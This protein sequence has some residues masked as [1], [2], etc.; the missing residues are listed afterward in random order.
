MSISLKHTDQFASD[1]VGVSSVG[2]RIKATRESLGY[3]VDDLAVTCGL[4][5]DEIID[6]EEGRDAD[7]ARLKRIAPALQVSVESLLAGN[8]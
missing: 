5:N 4:A 7:P 1:A 8:A 3:S 6:I 2:S